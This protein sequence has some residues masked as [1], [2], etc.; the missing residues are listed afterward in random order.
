[1][2]YIYEWWVSGCQ[3]LRVMVVIFERMECFAWSKW[4]AL[5]FVS[6]CVEGTL[7]E[8]FKTYGSLFIDFKIMIPFDDTSIKF[9]SIWQ[10]LEAPGEEADIIII[11]NYI[12]CGKAEKPG[13]NMALGR[14]VASCRPATIHCWL[15][16]CFLSDSQQTFGYLPPRSHQDTGSILK[17]DLLILRSKS[18]LSRDK[19]S[20]MAGIYP[21][22]LSM[23]PMSITI[24]LTPYFSPNPL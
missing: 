17:L 4:L 10:F 22:I 14:F 7:C 11:S 12:A 2:E 23:G 13:L 19:G 8:H 6:V 3:R 20:L 1:M 16:Y 24:P 18:K 15:T 5:A 21:K 9:L